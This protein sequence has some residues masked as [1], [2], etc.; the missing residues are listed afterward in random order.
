MSE[1]QYLAGIRIAERTRMDFVLT[2]V[3]IALYSFNLL[4]W[5]ATGVVR[6][7]SYRRRPWTL[8]LVKSAPRPNRGSLWRINHV[9]LFVLL[10]PIVISFKLYVSH[11]C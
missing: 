10:A 3:I 5:L 11:V 8:W 6:A 2:D 4:I 9:A 7:L 1:P